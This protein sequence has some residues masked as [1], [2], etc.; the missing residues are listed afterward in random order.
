ML[1]LTSNLKKFHSKSV[2]Y[3]KN[4]KTREKSSCTFSMVPKLGA[5]CVRSALGYTARRCGE[6]E[7]ALVVKGYATFHCRG[8]AANPPGGNGWRATPVSDR[9]VLPSRCSNRIDMPALNALTGFEIQVMEIL[10]VRRRVYRQ[11]IG[12]GRTRPSG[13]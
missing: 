6:A 9:L 4:A 1:P 10:F 2:T 5:H 3:I 11:L 12:T 13:A 7:P 8:P